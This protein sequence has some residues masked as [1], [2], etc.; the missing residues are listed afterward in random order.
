MYASFSEL[1]PITVYHKIYIFVSFNCYYLLLPWGVSTNY[2]NTSTF[3]DM[4]LS[5][6]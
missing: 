5:E 4:F 6:H 1:L 2:G 3:F